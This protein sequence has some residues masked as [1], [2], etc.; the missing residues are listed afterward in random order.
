MECCFCK[1]I[2]GNLSSLNNHKATAKYCL[3]IQNKSIDEKFKCLSCDKNF[4]AKN[5]LFAHSKTCNFV[6]KDLS[7]LEKLEEKEKELIEKNIIIAKQESIIEHLQKQ[8][9]I[10]R[11]Q[12]RELQDKLERLATTAISKPTTTNNNTKI[13]FNNSLDLSHERIFSIVTSKLNGEHIVDGMAGIA[14]FV[15][16]EI[17]TDKDGS[18]L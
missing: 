1:K 10:F 16:D 18:L 5:T 2:L 11:E 13:T 12:L 6:K 8:E 9:D 7:V 14:R 3:K 4:T 15:K 17:I